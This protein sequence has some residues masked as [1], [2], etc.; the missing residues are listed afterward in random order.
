MSEKDNTE[1]LKGIENVKDGT[2]L[3]GDNSAVC[4]ACGEKM[5]PKMKTCPYCKTKQPDLRFPS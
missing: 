1:K 3:F 4:F 5:V 2:I